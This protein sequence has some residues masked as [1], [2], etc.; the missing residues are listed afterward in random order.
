MALE[1]SATPFLRPFVW[2]RQLYDWVLGLAHKPHG[3]RALFLIAFSESSFFPVPPDILLIPLAIGAPKRSLWFSG[4]CTL[5]S[6]LGAVL[7]YLLGMK[8]YGTVGQTI[9][10]FYGVGEQYQRVQ[11]LYQEWD[12]LALAVA[13]FTPIPF[14]VFTIAAGV[15]HINIWT[16]FLASLLSRGARFFL[17]GGLVWWAGPGVQSFIDRYF[18]LLCVVFTIF[19]VGGFLVVKYAI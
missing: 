2:L 17:L 13:G 12:F 15:F 19:L 16:F 4:I 9:I 14:K 1:S 6:V 3:G 8:F 18:N 10:E 7:G 5:G 11:G